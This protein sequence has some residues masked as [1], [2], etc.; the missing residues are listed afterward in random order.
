MKIGTMT[1]PTVVKF[2][3]RNP[4][5][6]K[7]TESRVGELIGYLPDG[8]ARIKVGGVVH[9]IAE[10]DLFNATEIKGRSEVA[11]TD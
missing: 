7:P 3:V 1:D 11:Q 5:T 10:K 6:G 4:R 9:Y 8:R 2:I